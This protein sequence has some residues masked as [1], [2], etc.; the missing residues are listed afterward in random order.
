[1]VQLWLK[2]TFLEIVK[3]EVANPPGLHVEI[4]QGS[5]IGRAEA[6]I[7]IPTMPDA[8]NNVSP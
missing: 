1:M 4:S 8:T 5:L 2:L 6:V 7:G 3:A